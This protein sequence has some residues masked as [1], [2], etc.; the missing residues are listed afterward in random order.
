MKKKTITVV[1]PECYSAL[2]ALFLDSGFPVA[3]YSGKTNEGKERSVQ[4][5]QEKSFTN[6][7][8]MQKLPQA[9]MFW[10][11]HTSYWKHASCQCEKRFPV[12]VYELLYLFQAETLYF[13]QACTG[14]LTL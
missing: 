7:I 4:D 6:N 8:P 5:I 11:R 2:T 14:P 3:K 12:S 9:D 10:R 13:Q 1:Q